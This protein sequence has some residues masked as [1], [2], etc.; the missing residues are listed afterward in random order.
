M[1]VAKGVGQKTSLFGLTQYPK[2][3]GHELPSNRRDGWFI[4]LFLTRP[5]SPEK[6]PSWLHAV[7][8]ERANGSRWPSHHHV[9][10]SS[11]GDLPVNTS[12]LSNQFQSN[13]LFQRLNVISLIN[14]ITLTWLRNKKKK[15]LK[16]KR[17]SFFTRSTRRAMV[18]RCE[19]PCKST[20]FAKPL[21]I[22]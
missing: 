15:S 4:D 9:H 7:I 22:G 19:R 13:H 8:N 20:I 10:H 11:N 14:H 16:I 6:S 2:R 3:L 18:E 1:P 5:L 17:E 21:L 12:R